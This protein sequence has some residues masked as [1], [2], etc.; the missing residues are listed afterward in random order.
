[1]IGPTVRRLGGRASAVR[2]GRALDPAG[3][4]LQDDAER[5]LAE[6]ARNI[7]D[8]KRYDEARMRAREERLDL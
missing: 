4:A 2:L 3:A 8:Q 7:A 5:R 6:Y 1:V